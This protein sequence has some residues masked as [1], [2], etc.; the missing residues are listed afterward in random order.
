MGVDIEAIVRRVPAWS[1][2]PLAIR[3]L[4]GGITNRNY[5]ITV[6]GDEY[7]VRVPGERTEPVSYTHLTLPTI[8]RV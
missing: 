1:R 6:D 2:A 4:S 3:P 5:V 7:V 8:L